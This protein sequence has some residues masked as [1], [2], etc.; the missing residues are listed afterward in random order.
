MCKETLK[1]TQE[2]ED[3]SSL[4]SNL[5]SLGLEPVPGGSRN[6]LTGAEMELTGTVGERRTIIVDVAN[7]T[8][9]AIAL[10]LGPL[11]LDSPVIQGLEKGPDLVL[12]LE[13]ELSGVDACE[14]EGAFV[15]GVEVEVR[16]EEVGGVE[17]E[18]G[19]AF[20]TAVD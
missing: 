18:V 16:W 10:D 14:G 12:F 13:S 8:A 20:P 19:S 3:E 7:E 4:R 6:D 1:S 5:E 11:P 17:V 2:R 15:A 9:T